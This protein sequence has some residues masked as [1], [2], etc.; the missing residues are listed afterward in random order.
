MNGLA[1]F[2]QIVDQTQSQVRAFVAGMGMRSDYVDDMAQEVYLEFYRNMAKMPPEAEPLAWL[3]GMA[4]RMCLN[5][6]RRQKRI[7]QRRLAT[8]AELLAR[9]ETA[10]ER[11]QGRE[12][13]Q[14]VLHACLA[15]LS[16]GN[17][18]MV[19]LRYEQGLTSQ[20]IGRA[21]QRSAEAVRIG[22][23]RVRAALKDCIVQR[24]TEQA[25]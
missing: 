22:L 10:W 12:D 9:T 17:R 18:R 5:H 11:G 23:L 21:L 25:T 20:A 1:A 6:F 2:E 13:I 8:V 24:M 4:R 19:K 14:Q 16:E 3:K 7:E 15:A